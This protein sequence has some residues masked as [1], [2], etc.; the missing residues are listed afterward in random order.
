MGQAKNRGTYEERK[1]KALGIKTAIQQAK[2]EVEKKQREYL[3]L[4]EVQHEIYLRALNSTPLE[5][6]RPVPNKPEGVV[7]GKSRYI[8]P[9]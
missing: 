5:L 6:P 2:E 8:K 4:P 3:A 9:M 1:A 7:R